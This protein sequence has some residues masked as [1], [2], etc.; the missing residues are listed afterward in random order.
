[1]LL[2][3][4]TTSFRSSSSGQPAKGLGKLCHGLP[5]FQENDVKELLSNTYSLPEPIQASMLRETQF[6]EILG[7][8]T[9]NHQNGSTPKTS[10]S[11]QG[12]TSCT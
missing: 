10:D 8:I 7:D 12:R 5:A 11:E 9:E 3:V 1:M 6:N 4:C 2:H